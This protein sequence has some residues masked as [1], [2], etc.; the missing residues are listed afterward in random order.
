VSAIA[1]IVP[2]LQ[3]LLI[4]LSS[5]QPGEVVAAAAAIKRILKSAGC[6]YHDLVAG[7]GAPPSRTRRE[8]PPHQDHDADWRALRAF[9]LEQRS[10][11]RGREL[12][13]LTSIGD[14]RRDLS[15]KQFAWLQSIQARL[16]RAG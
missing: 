1:H 7:L 15:A 4:L 16:K 8:K 13:F 2:K 14:W 10:L 5:D 9:C 12:D 11:L 6:D 3:R